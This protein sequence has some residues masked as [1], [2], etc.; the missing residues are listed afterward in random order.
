MFI[1]FSIPY[2][3]LQAVRV[4]NI[5]PVSGIIEECFK[6]FRDEKDSGPLTL[7][8]I[9]LLVGI[10]LPLW[11]HP[12]E[13]VSSLAPSSGIISIGFG[14]TAASVI[15]NLLGSHKW[16]KS[17]KTIEGSVGAFVAQFLSSMWL[18]NYFE[19]VLTMQVVIPIIIISAIVAVIEA[20]TTQIDNLIL[21]LYHYLLVSVFKMVW[22][23][24]L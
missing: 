20:K 8:H 15:G 22:N 18:L 21:P 1:S 24:K 16:K 2:D 14:D 10:S 17:K 23:E 13:D 12:S 19:T 4:S 3:C 11:M 6:S 7:T 9:Y 5:Q